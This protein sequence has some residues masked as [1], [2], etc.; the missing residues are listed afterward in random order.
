MAKKKR[1]SNESASRSEAE[2]ETDE[3][4]ADA[5]SEPRFEESVARLESIVDELQRSDIS[6]DD[7]LRRYEEGVK[8]VRTC[9]AML[10]AAEQRIEIVTGVTESGEIEVEAFGEEAMSLEEKEA[11]RS[12]RRSR[13]VR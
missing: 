4:M 13:D 2:S 8:C 12:R 6:L 7:A 1:T 10:R 9:H 5:A 11:N 3:N